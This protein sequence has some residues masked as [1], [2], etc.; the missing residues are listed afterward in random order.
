MAT[1][2]RRALLLHGEYVEAQRL[3]LAKLEAAERGE[4][5]WPR[6]EEYEAVVR[7][8]RLALAEHQRHLEELRDCR[9]ESRIGRI[10]RMSASE[11]HWQPS[12]ELWLSRQQDTQ[13]AS[14]DG[15]R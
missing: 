10:Q 6:A 4:R 14:R 11:R 1:A 2:L 9:R 12:A 7:V 3:L 15:G 8:G 13:G 5:P